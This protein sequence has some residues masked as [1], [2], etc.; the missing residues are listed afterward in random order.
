MKTAISI[1]DGLFERAEAMARRLGRSRSQIYRDALAE[2]IARHE[3]NAVTASLDAAVEEIGTT[4][5]DPWSAEAGRRV[6][7]STEW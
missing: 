4:T 2:Y 5:L 1:P 6:L 7:E 3:P